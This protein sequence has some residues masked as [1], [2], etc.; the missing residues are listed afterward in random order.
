MIEEEFLTLA[1]NVLAAISPNGIWLPAKWALYKDLKNQVL[2]MDIPW[3]LTFEEKRDALRFGVYNRPCC[4]CGAYARMYHGTAMKKYGLFSRTC[5]KPSC[6][7]NDPATKA[8]IQQTIRDRHGSLKNPQIRLKAKQTLAL[9]P[10]EEKKK[11]TRKQV[12]TSLA[13]Y[14]AMFG[15]Q[16]QSEEQYKNTMHKMQA[17]VQEQHGVKSMLQLQDI[18]IRA[19]DLAREKY[20]AEVLPKTIGALHKKGLIVEP[21]WRGWREQHNAH[22]TVCNTG[23]KLKRLT[24]EAHCPNCFTRSKP[25]LFISQ[26]LTKADVNFLENTRKVLPGR[27]LDFF[28]PEI[29]LGIEVNG[30]YWH[31]DGVGFPL[32]EK[33]KL[34]EAHGIQLL[35]FWEHEIIDRPA[36]VRNMVLAK[37]GRAAKIHARKTQCMIISSQ[38]ANDF[39]EEHHISGGA[40]CSV[41]LALE[42]DDKVMAVATFARPRFS[43]G[44]IELVRFASIG[45]VVGGLSK[46]LSVVKD[47]LITFADKRFSSGRTAYDVVGFRLIGET[48]P[49]YFY[50]RGYKIVSRYAAQKHK[51]S[52]LLGDQFDPKKT[53]LENMTHAGYHRCTD[54]GNFKYELN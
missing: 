53:E 20:I 40:Q 6:A 32:L 38:E 18:K 31:R 54:C 47:Q 34:A 22:C 29:N 21:V 49:N 11:S 30:L 37:I 33:T 17:R 51:L 39:L 42:L 44:A 24:L 52:A 15:G 25:Q 3:Y 10:D 12:A 2:A 46:L 36:A 5:T 14:G 1:S 35:H 48:K 50:H 28:L 13:R 19:R 23:V 43:Q 7:M 16:R 4:P 45:V 41:A 9:R 8:R 26:L 27:E